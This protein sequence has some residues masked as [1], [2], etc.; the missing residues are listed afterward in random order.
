MIRN[1]ITW[2]QGWIL[3]LICVSVVGAYAQQFKNI[4]EFNRYDDKIRLQLDSI[5][6]SLDPEYDKLTRYNPKLT[7]TDFNAH[8]GKI[9]KLVKR[10]EERIQQ[11]QN[12]L[13]TLPEPNNLTSNYD[14]KDWTE[15]RI[16]HYQT[17][18]SDSQMLKMRIKELKNKISGLKK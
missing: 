14:L 5:S 4:G 7:E 12:A 2:K 6:K 11:C 18:I 1:I 16:L 15:G 9:E 3:L 10:Y 13:K 17:I 8:I